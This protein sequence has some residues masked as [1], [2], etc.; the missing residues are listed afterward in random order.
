MMMA[1]MIVNIGVREM[2]L[3]DTILLTFT[4]YIYIDRS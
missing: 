3:I 4:P 1:G 2:H